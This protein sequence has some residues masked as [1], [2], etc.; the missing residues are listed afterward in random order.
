MFRDRKNTTKEKS[1]N[2]SEKPGKTPALL[3][4][5]SKYEAVYCWN[6]INIIQQKTQNVVIEVIVS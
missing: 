3:N 1:M 5:S 4:A 2:Q 6:A